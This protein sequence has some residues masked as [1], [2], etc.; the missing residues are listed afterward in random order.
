MRF[1]PH[2][3][4]TFEIDIHPG[5]TEYAI[6][7]MIGDVQRTPPAVPLC[8]VVIRVRAANTRELSETF[9]LDHHRVPAL[10]RG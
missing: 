1:G 9:K 2:R 10:Y 6:V 3:D 7:L 4:E 5:S 8:D